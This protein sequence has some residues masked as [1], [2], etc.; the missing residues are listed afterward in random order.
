MKPI[1]A[2]FA[3]YQKLHIALLMERKFRRGKFIGQSKQYFEVL[4]SVLGRCGHRHQSMDTARPCL[5][6]M[7]GMMKAR[8][9]TR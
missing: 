4:S 9:K 2:K 5:S 3:Y 6:K 8:R 1:K 7:S